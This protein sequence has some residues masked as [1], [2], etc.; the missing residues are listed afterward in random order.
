MICATS[1]FAMNTMCLSIFASFMFYIKAFCEDF[2]QLLDQL[3]NSLKLN[4]IE[5][6]MIESKMLLKIFKLQ[7]S[8]AK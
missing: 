6:Q 7:K 3:D 1:H 4:R 8:I 5:N 2:C